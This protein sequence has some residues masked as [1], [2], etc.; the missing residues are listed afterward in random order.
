MK[1]YF[2]LFVALITGA[3]SVY[4]QKEISIS[5]LRPIPAAFT[6]NK[7]P[8]LFFGIESS[9]R[10]VTGTCEIYD[11]DLNKVASFDISDD[12]QYERFAFFNENGHDGEGSDLCLSQTL[13]NDD[14]DWEYICGDYVASEGSF[15]FISYTLQSYIIKKT[16]GE[17]LGV[18]DATKYQ[19][20]RPT[21]LFL[22]DNCFVCLG[23]N[24]VDN[25]YGYFKPT[26]YKYYTLTEFRKLI[27]DNSSSVQAVPSFVM[28][29]NEQTYDLS[30]RKVAPGTKGIVVKNNK[31]FLQ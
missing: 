24:L 17:V 28:P 15:G 18:L 19:L 10:G 14:E 7:V 21:I 11:Y 4:G 8:Y 12:I 9:S 25:G 20:S 31:K 26:V 1:K 27:A 6:Y 2:Y 3:V 29:A 13:F 30:G 23:E 16:N 5:E 22:G